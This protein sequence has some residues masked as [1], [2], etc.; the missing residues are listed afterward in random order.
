MKIYCSG[1]GGI[2][3]SAYAALQKQEGHTVSGSDRSDSALLDALRMQEIMIFLN[4]DGS[5]LTE[6]IDLFVYSE[7]ISED[8]PERVKA[9]KL[10]IKSISYFQALGEY[11]T[12][13]NLRV[14]AVCGTHGKSSTTAMLSKI[15]IDA[16]KDPTVVVGT[17]AVDLDGKNWRKGSSD[18]AIIEA[19][20]YRGSFLHLPP[21]SIVL[22]TADGDHFDAFA[23]RKAYEEVFVQFFQ[24]LP[25]NGTVIT[26]GK[27]PLTAGLVAQSG[28]TLIDADTVDLP[29]LKN[30][31]G[32]HMRQNAALA[33]RAAVEL[34]IS[35]SEA[36]KSLVEF[37]GTWR[38]MEYRGMLNGTIP[39]I[40]DYAH[41]P[42]EIRA[43]L[44]A[45]K[46]QYAGRRLL[47]VFQPH[48]WS[49]TAELY[50]E[51]VLAFKGAGLVMLTDVYKARAEQEGVVDM[52]TFAQ[53]IAQKSD[54][55]CIYSGS[56]SETEKVLMTHLE[57]ND[58]VI[59][60]GAGTIA[61]LADKLVS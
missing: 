49:R 45:M 37:G 16:G 34:G 32:L 10:A 48:L 19:C 35:E 1:I 39:L 53:E 58:V 4:Q 9:R 15:C 24:K 41:H 20:E 52:S 40:D 26:H 47:C 46:E 17:K 3:L 18:L 55:E 60:M 27:D 43:T 5:G 38:R 22:T 61:D 31:P 51:F 23:N 2:G 14:V 6:D 50:H 25:Q 8:A 12:E 29:E 56:L 13:K 57:S 21:S 28:K 7:A 11:L 33:L 54:V 42:A 59:V 44:S 30:V 36:R